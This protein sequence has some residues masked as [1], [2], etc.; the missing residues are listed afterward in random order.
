[1]RYW[2][3]CKSE[4]K[5]VYCEVEGTM[6][7]YLVDS[8]VELYGRKGQLDEEYFDSKMNEYLEKLYEEAD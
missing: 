3:K 5:F 6:R 7:D 8:I 4:D 2:K 1:M